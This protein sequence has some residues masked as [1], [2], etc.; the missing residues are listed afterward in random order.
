MG[1]LEVLVV[2]DPDARETRDGRERLA[3]VL[4]E[5]GEEPDSCELTLDEEALERAAEAV[6][7]T[8][9]AQQGERYGG[10]AELAGRLP[11]MSTPEVRALLE[12][13]YGNDDATIV[14]TVYT[15]FVRRVTEVAGIVSPAARAEQL[16]ASELW[17]EAGQPEVAG[18][19]AG[20]AALV[21]ERLGDDDTMR[22][23][24]HQA[25]GLLR[26]TPS[27]VADLDGL[28]A[29]YGSMLD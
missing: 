19:H 9:L 14:A 26:G 13:A 6:S 12:R 2:A 16:R 17:A 1:A 24:G 3:G 8:D 22:V 27:E 21:T 20:L 5:L 15:E 10:H 7:K 11:G 18:M 4:R 25:L 23:G 28:R 29:A